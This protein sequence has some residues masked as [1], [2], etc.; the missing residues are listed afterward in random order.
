MSSPTGRRKAKY[1]IALG[2]ILALA[3]VVFS[4]QIA[5]AG[6]ALDV[7]P[8]T[9]LLNIKVDGQNPYYNGTYDWPWAFTI[10]NSQGQY[11]LPAW[12]FEASPNSTSP[13]LYLFKTFTN[14]NASL[15]SVW[16]SQKGASIL[17]PPGNY[18]LQLYYFY[19]AAYPTTGT[20]IVPYQSPVTVNLN[21]DST[22]TLNPTSVPPGYSGGTQ[23]PPPSGSALSAS[24]VNIVTI[25]GAAMIG[26]G[27]YIQLKK[28]DAKA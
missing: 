10:E 25:L 22:V 20:V 1:L 19:P 4:A 8:N 13:Y 24:Y 23:Y 28:P 11:G 18:T 16:L 17:C 14:N 5:E 15:Y 3:G 21:Q 27:G 9:H 7:A 26:W 2:L 12:T 6:F